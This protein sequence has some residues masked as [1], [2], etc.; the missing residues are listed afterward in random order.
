MN[1]DCMTDVLKDPA[2]QNRSIDEVVDS[3]NGW[4]DQF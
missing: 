3:V 2:Q 1:L 4:L